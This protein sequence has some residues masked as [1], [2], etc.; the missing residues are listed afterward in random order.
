MGWNLRRLRVEKS[1][2]QEALGLL[3][4]CEPSYIGRIERGRENSTVETLEALAE[5]L[6]VHIS[7]FFVIPKPGSER[8]ATLRRGRKPKTAATRPEEG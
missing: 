8:P 2:S 7:A 6:G 1:L 5:V 4:E 3:A